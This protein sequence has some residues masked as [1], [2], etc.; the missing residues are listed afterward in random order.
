LEAL[1]AAARDAERALTSPEVKM[2]FAGV[3]RLT[4]AGVELRGET[5]RPA[6]P[7][8]EAEEAARTGATSR[9]PPRL[10]SGSARIGSTLSSRHRTAS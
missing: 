9:G 10:A 7:E 8:A 3:D 5:E 2:L 4:A 1:L 6:E